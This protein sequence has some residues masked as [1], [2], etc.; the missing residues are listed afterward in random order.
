M[1]L[2]CFE[3]LFPD[4]EPTP[5]TEWTHPEQ[6]EG[7]DYVDFLGRAA[8]YYCTNPPPSGEHLRLIECDN[9]THWPEWE[10]DDTD[11]YPSGCS[12]CLMEQMR[13]SADELA[14][15]HHWVDHPLRGKAA[16]RV[17]SWAK[18]MGIVAGY[19][20]N[21]GGPTACNGCITGIRWRGKRVYILGR[22]TRYYRESERIRND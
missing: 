5:M 11:F 22:M 14:C 2:A 10:I 12:S 16:A 19:G 17:L 18:R 9:P 21:Y 13:A 15:R 4:E 8:T 6:G 7:E 20:L 3:H 1:T